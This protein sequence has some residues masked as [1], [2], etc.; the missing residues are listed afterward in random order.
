VRTKWKKN[1]WS[2]TCQDTCSCFKCLRLMLFFTKAHHWFVSWVRW[3]HFAPS[4]TIFVLFLFRGATA[5]SGPGPPRYRGFMITLRHTTLGRT[6]LYEWS[7]RRR[8]LHLTTHITHKRQTFLPPAG[9]QP[10]ISASERPQTH[11][12]DRTATEV[13]CN[14]DLISTSR[15]VKWCLSFGL[16]DRN[17]VGGFFSS[18]FAAWC[19]LN[20]LKTNQSLNVL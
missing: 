5:H 12:L 11:A 1:W 8:D 17:Y 15:S 7:A 2:I 4:H 10:P 19:L 20:P 14:I 3:I 18:M 9:F 6:P 13:C 16:P